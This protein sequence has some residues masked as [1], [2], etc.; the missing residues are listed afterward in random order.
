MLSDPYLCRRQ[1]V[2]LLSSKCQ[3]QFFSILLHFQFDVYVF[4]SLTP[5]FVSFVLVKALKLA[6][7]LFF[8]TFLSLSFK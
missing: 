5:D 4:I 7:R 6:G 8:F 3:A 2:D 1:F